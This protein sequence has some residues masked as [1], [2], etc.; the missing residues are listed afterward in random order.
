MRNWSTLQHLE[1]SPKIPAFLIAA[2]VDGVAAGNIA[3]RISSVQLAGCQAIC[4]PHT[5]AKLS[6]TIRNLK[7]CH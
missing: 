3:G 2:V 5:A 7:Y 4:L 1:H 6:G